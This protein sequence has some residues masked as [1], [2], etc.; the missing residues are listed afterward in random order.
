MTIAQKVKTSIK[1][2]TD[3]APQSDDVTMLIFKYKGMQNNIKTYKELAIKENYS[4][5]YNWLHRACKDMEINEDLAN[6]LDMCA[7]EIFANITFYAYPVKA[8]KIEANLK[9]SQENIIFEI[10]DEGIEYNPLEKSDPDISL[11]PEERPIGG[12]GIFMIKEMSD[13]I[14]YK[15]ENNQNILTLVFKI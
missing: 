7:E 3:S 2:Y 12:L 14:T 11:P 1:E 5:F 8:G 10:R 13:E 4:S 15:R 6:K 9:K